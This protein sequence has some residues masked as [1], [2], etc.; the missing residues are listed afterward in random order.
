MLPDSIAYF[1]MEIALQ[2]DIPT[3]SGGLGV[4]AGDTLRAAADLELPVVGVSLVHRQG[5]FRQQLDELGRQSEHPCPWNVEEHIS[6][7]PGKVSIEVHNREV[8]IRC[9]KY[10]VIG[11]TG[12]ALPVYLLDTELQENSEYDRKLTDHL[13]GGDR[14][15]RLCQ[16]MILGVGGVRIL[17]MLGFENLVRYHMNEGHSAFLTAELLT[18][19][20][21]RTRKKEISSEA[22]KY[23]RSK[24]VF[25]THT[26]VDAGHDRFEKEMVETV[27]N[28][29]E[30]SETSPSCS[31]AMKQLLDHGI[32]DTAGIHSPI[33]DGDTFN[34]TL[35]GL[36]MAGYV[37]GVARKHGEVS[38]L[39][40]AGYEIDA[41]TNGVHAR[42]WVS[43]SLSEVFDRHIPGWRED[44][45]CLRYALSIPFEEIISAHGVSK[46]AL[47][48][49]IKQRTGEEFQIE[50]FIVGF[51]RRMTAYKRPDLLFQ[52]P[53]R[54]KSIAE[55]H[56]G[57]QL[58]F[59]GKA[60]PHDHHGKKII[61][62]I[63][64]MKKTLGPSVSLVFLENY[65]ME[66][67]GLMIA[68]VDLWLNTP[69]PP[70]EASG[71]SGMKAALNGVPSLS[72][73]D[74]WWIEG[75]FEGITGWAIGGANNPESTD[76]PNTHAQSLYQK[77]DEQILPMYYKHYSQYA[78]IMAHA[79]ALNGVFFNTQRM[80]QQYL[81]KAYVSRS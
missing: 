48:D 31:G 8:F 4:L 10:E 15:Y 74:G 56:G 77:L 2:S 76:N 37:N 68:G 53:E 19:Y 38:R 33:E 11:A 62:H 73:L 22:I 6:K 79:I 43:P 69:Q 72:V 44:S 23:V 17:K 14:Y 60:H 61:E 3:Y 36:S 9:W 64:E 1:S 24:C 81:Q 35:L 45:Y 47:F 13:Y 46:R 28:I 70:L 34:M 51:S 39:M 52:D 55:E 66:A 7:I 54:L 80:V 32:T 29:H 63:Y 42:T 40:F 25:T 20:L 59:A 41:I 65:G 67:A 50:K 18:G 75:C 30:A 27:F 58:V 26:P 71:T 57:L 78:N 16:E 5:Y 49:E 21:R 12:F